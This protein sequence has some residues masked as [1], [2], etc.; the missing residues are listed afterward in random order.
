MNTT[1][2]ETVAQK[3]VIELVA[4]RPEMQQFFLPNPP[5]FFYLL[6]NKLF[7]TFFVKTSTLTWKTNKQKIPSILCFSVQNSQKP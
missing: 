3:G 4:L 7:N 5:F 2:T 1:D 6:L